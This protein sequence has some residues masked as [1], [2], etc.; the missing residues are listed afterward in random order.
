MSKVNRL[1]ASLHQILGSVWEAPATPAQ[2]HHELTILGARV[3]SGGARPSVDRVREAVQAFRKHGRLETAEQARRACYGILE[4]FSDG[5]TALIEHRLGFPKL[6]T[7]VDRFRGD[8]RK[9]RRCYRALLDC[10]FAL[11]T[12]ALDE[13]S[14]RASNWLRLAN[15]LEKNFVR[16]RIDGI[17]PEW[18]AVL[19]KHLNLIGED[20]VSRYGRAALSG[21]TSEFDE[22]RAG[23][24][25]GETSWVIRKVVIAQVNA[26]C[27]LGDDGFKSHVKSLCQLIE[28]HALV[29][30][31]GLANLINR[32]VSVAAKSE[33][34]A[35]RD[36]A[37][38]SWGNPLV[39]TNKSK[40][41]L[42]S[43][44]GLRM[45]TN[46]LKLDLI[47]QF[48]AVL[49]D[50]RTTDQRR[51]R[52]WGNY[53]EIIDGMYFA[54][55]PKTA[56]SKKSDVQV[57]RERMGDLR[58]SLVHG[59]Q[60]NNAFI[61]LIGAYALVEFGETGN[62]CFIFERK[63]LPFE[64][65]GDVHGNF[66]GLKNEHHKARL[67]HNGEWEIEFEIVLKRLGIEAGSRALG[68]RR[69][70]RRPSSDSFDETPG[71]VLSKATL[72]EFLGRNS[73][74]VRDMTAKG[75][76]L[77]VDLK[78]KTGPRADQLRAWGFKFAPSRKAWYRRSNN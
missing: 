72:R 78:E 41:H 47:Q 11:E 34:K 76:N 9:F 31:Q 1:R 50:D 48:F 14:L 28:D 5:E 44:D 39:V 51:V 62:A 40:W 74:S 27:A 63:N 7:E 67:I 22:F 24:D 33:D 3:K 77:W 8:A 42:V 64:L 21:D 13:N 20:P 38:E 73:L 37:L 2:L 57:L 53:H 60:R 16:V 56:Q 32:Y 65:K 49:A 15:Y 6:L 35:L 66:I 18:V 23:L 26:A 43:A 46:W 19:A 69:T 29:R 68:E 17:E 25:I 10:Y 59:G 55:G 45:V 70:A 12:E 4:G 52:F 75:G 58:L 71:V 54:L 61:M 30:D 36:A